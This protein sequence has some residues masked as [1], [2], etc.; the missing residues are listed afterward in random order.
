VH[1]QRGRL[2]RP[3]Q[4]GKEVLTGMLLSF[5]RGIYSSGT[6]QEAPR[7]REFVRTSDDTIIDGSYGVSIPAEIFFSCFVDS[8][9]DVGVS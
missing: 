3:R 6:L 1:I 4:G 8:C 7:P 2:R 5:S 9:F